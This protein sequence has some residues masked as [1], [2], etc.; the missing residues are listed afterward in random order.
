V[1]PGFFYRF[2]QLTYFLDTSTDM[3]LTSLSTTIRTIGLIAIL[4]AIQ[5]MSLV[6]AAQAQAD[7][8][9]GAVCTA[10][11]FEDPGYMY[12]AATPQQEEAI[13]RYSQDPDR[14]KRS[15]RMMAE[16]TTFSAPLDSP[17]GYVI[18]KVNGK[19]VSIPPAIRRAMDQGINRDSTKDNRRRV[20]E[21]NKKYGQYATFG[22]NINLIL[23]P[24]QVK[25]QD[26]DIYDLLAYIK[27]LLTPQQQKEQRDRAIAAP[28]KDGHCSPG[29]I[30]R[31]NTFLT[32]SIDTGK[33]PDL[34]KRLREDKTGTTFFK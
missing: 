23:S 14:I 10:A 27:S 16:I 15:E 26:Q 4:S 1:N 5:G 13:N 24:E 34:D 9:A 31:P 30:F 8:N 29:A 17:M 6:K 22:Q 11:Y 21:L 33:R 25:E 19:E 2:S 28:I 3:Q 20:A 12:Q 7:P 18:N 32:R